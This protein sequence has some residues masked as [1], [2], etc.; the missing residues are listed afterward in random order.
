MVL[1]DGRSALAAERLPA[2][3]AALAHCVLCAHRCGV[4]RRY[5]PAGAC[6]AGDQ[7]RV[8]SAQIE[9]GDEL[10]FLPTYAIALSGCDIRCSFCVTGRESWDARAGASLS[11]RALAGQAGAAWASG[12]AKTVMILGGEPT[13]HVP[14]LLEFAAALPEKTPLVLKTNGVCTAA[15]RDLLAGLFDTWLVDF[16]FGNDACASAVARIP[17][18]V[19]AVQEALAWAAAESELVVRHLLLPGH[20]ECCWRPIA[21][22]LAAQMPGVKVSLCFGYW[23]AWVAAKSGALAR[24]ISAEEQASAL[25]IAREARLNLIS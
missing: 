5:G 21:R 1:L 4:D 23:P 22:R 6:K 2:A 10:E 16:K 11:A 7:A 20:V 15:A 24:G 19:A 12:A 8:F 25:A 13:I 18:Y 9:V 14:W 3:G 17:G